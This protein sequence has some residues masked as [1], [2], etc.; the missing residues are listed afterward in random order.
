MYTITGIGITTSVGQGK[1]TMKTALQY[2]QSAFG[3]LQR[4]GRQKESFFIGAEI[5]PLV[6][7]GRFSAKILRS[8]SLTTQT[9][10]VTLQEAWQD[11]G[12]DAVS[13]DRIG[14]IAGGSNLQQRE[15]HQIDHWSWPECCR[16]CGGGSRFVTNANWLVASVQKS[17]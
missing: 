8:A 6:F 13:P 11:A 12:L 10:L 14:L 7:P 15:Y 16:C 4:P 17:G 9:A 1:E 3:I 2:G 5:P